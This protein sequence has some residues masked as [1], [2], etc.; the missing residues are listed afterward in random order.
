M[1]SNNTTTPLKVSLSSITPNNIGTVRK[2]NS[3]LFPIKYSEKFYKDIQAPE[4][5][6]FCKL[7]VFFSVTSDTL[8]AEQLI[9]KYL[10]YY[11]DIPVGTICCRQET[12]D[13]QNV[14]YL[15]TM[16]ILAPYRSRKLGSQTLSAIL[17]A[18]AAHKPKVDKIYLHVQV[19]N[20]D[21]KRFYE[22][23]DFKEIRVHENYYKKITPAD[24]W[25]LEKAFS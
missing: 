24:A 7:G 12:V 8:R 9:T 23:H 25:V 4:V 17:T 2:L 16:G 15:M 1:S 21:A 14:L 19:S 22:S 6:D 20:E 10:V 13:G 5:E 3:V 18:A 11:N